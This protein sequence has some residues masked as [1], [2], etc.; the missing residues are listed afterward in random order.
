MIQDCG[1][2]E[3]G[4]SRKTFRTCLEAR[5]LVLQAFGMP[6]GIGEVSHG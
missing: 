2:N 6:G 4:R 1:M 5:E 3:R